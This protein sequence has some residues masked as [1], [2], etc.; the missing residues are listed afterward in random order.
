MKRI[1]M[2]YAP[3]IHE[4]YIKLFRKYRE[5]V[6]TLCILGNELVDEFTPLKR[7]IRAINPV[8]M[9]K[10]IQ[11]LN[12]FKAV[13][14]FDKKSILAAQKN[15]LKII[16]VNESVSLSVAEK[17]FSN[18]SVKFDSMFL[19]WDEKSVKS[20]KPVNYNR[21]SADVFDRKMM[22]LANREAQK[23]S[24]WWYHVGAVAV[25]DGKVL[26]SAYNHHVPSEF[27]PYVNGDPRDFIEAGTLTHFATA[28]HAEQTILI[29]AA[30]KG[31]SL[32]GTDIYTTVFPCPFCA[33]LVAYSGIKRCFF[34][35]GHVSLDGEK[36]LKKKK[37]ELIFVKKAP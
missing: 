22:A 26:L 9:K 29:E 8:L 7:E 21:E 3:V 12:L 4:G 18:F 24:D 35:S 28:L 36:I 32:D 14:I 13:E 5:S 6:D 16:T 15:P 37:V 17:Y 25:K 23:S 30:R 10:I 20:A 31:V 1:L 19:R 33:K 2:L 34:S 27:M 11:S